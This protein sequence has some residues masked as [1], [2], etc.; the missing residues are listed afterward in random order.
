MAALRGRGVLQ[1]A[2]AGL[3]AACALLLGACGAE[4]A[5]GTAASETA[6]S[7]ASPAPS[8]SAVASA[9]AA[10]RLEAA[11]QATGELTLAEVPDWSGAP[12]VEVFGNE[13]DFTEADLT[14]NTYLGFSE[15]DGL[16]R[17]GRAVACLG[18]ETVPMEERG[19]ISEIKP[20][21]WH[22]VSYDVVEGGSLYNRC[23]S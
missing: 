22:S 12:S 16:G 13:P 10:A 5:Q 17:A 8:A 21:G 18:T 20:S 4:P 6:P 3:L 11:P 2:V 14:T 19:S 15:L 23:T 1:V 9:E 7:A